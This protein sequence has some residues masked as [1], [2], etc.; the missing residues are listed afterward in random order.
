M[1]L[2]RGATSAA[3]VTCGTTTRL[4]PRRST[5]HS[6]WT[7]VQPL[8]YHGR[9]FSLPCTGCPT[10]VHNSHADGTGDAA[11]PSRTQPLDAAQPLTAVTPMASTT[12]SRLPHAP[13]GAR[14]LYHHRSRR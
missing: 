12:R 5:P 10:D 14:D 11:A 9:S 8:E 4:A 3:T 13:A 2:G 7:P 6:R 1:V